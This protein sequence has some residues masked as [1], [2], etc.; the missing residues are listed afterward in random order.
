MRSVRA[1]VRKTIDDGTANLPPDLAAVPTTASER[2]Q[3][4]AAR[5]LNTD[6][7]EA[8]G[9][10]RETLVLVCLAALVALD[11]LSESYLLNLGVA[12]QTG[13]SLEQAR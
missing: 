8:S 11:A 1:H 7:S 10:D 4:A 6:A 2:T 9:L 13:V 5:G 3:R 12:S